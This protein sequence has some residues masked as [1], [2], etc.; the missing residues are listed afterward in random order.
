[1]WAESEPSPCDKNGTSV[2][3]PRHTAAPY[4]SDL[5]STCKTNDVAYPKTPSW[6]SAGFVLAIPNLNHDAH[7]GT[8]GAADSWLKTKV[9]QIENTTLYKSGTT[10]IEV[11]FDECGVSNCDGNHVYTAFANPLIPAGTIVKT[12][13]TH[14]SLLRLDE[15]LLGLPLL[16]KA[17]QAN[18]MRGAL[19][20]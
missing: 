19:G 7:N 2:Y 6:G 11:T 20:L 5:A 15:E 3:A 18:D 9:T 13:V 17:A 12:P 1:V 14:Y 4:Y 16:A 8:L 10:L